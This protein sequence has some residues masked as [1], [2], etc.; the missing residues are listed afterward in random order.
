MKALLTGSVEGSAAVF[1][2]LTTFTFGS[3]AW[4]SG[5]A[6]AGRKPPLGVLL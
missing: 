4:S 1:I 6:L 5:P 2:V 3:A